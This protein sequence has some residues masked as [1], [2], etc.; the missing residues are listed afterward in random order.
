[1]GPARIDKVDHVLLEFETRFRVGGERY[2]LIGER[3]RVMEEERGLGE[4]HYAYVPATFHFG[5]VASRRFTI[6][7]RVSGGFGSVGIETLEPW[8]AGPQ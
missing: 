7:T 2:L 8:I 5:S 4:G 3:M 1:M 6:A